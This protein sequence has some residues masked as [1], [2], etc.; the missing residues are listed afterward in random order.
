MG[1][2]TS[3]AL[4]HTTLLHNTVRT[5]ANSKPAPPLGSAVVAGEKCPLLMHE[6]TFENNLIEAS[7]ATSKPGEPVADT[8]DLPTDVSDDVAAVSVAK[9]ALVHANPQRSVFD[10]ASRK[11]RKAMHWSPADDFAISDAD[12]KQFTSV[13][14]H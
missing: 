1:D 6:C 5:K 7:G 2:D 9:S 4:H 13:W 11:S 3:A 14:A 8:F 12:F 10:N